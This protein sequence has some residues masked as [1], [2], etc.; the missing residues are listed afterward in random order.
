MKKL[1]CVL[2]ALIIVAAALPFGAS[3]AQLNAVL[4]P[5]AST[6]REND[7]VVVNLNFSN[8]KSVDGIACLDASI[9]YNPNVLEFVSLKA[10]SSILGLASSVP[11]PGKLLINYADAGGGFTAFNKNGTFVAI[12]F[13]VKK[14]APLGETTVTGTLSNILDPNMVDHTASLSSAKINILQPLSDNAFLSELK[15]NPGNLSPAFN[16]N[17]INYAVSVPY[18]VDKIEVEAKAEDSKAK[19]SISNPTLKAGSTTKITITVT[20]ENPSVKKVYTIN[21]TRGAN[22]NPTSS[23][24]SSSEPSS[25]VESSQDSG[26]GFE[27]ESSSEDE[28]L[29]PTPGGGF[30]GAKAV[31]IWILG[32]ILALASGFV[33]GIFWERKMGHDDVP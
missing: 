31:I 12:T 23:A 29:E 9:E 8:A 10:D 15:I 26:G 1:T 11:Q 13:K 5:G 18:S 6:A 16:K 19:V 28:S 33:G 20:A 7:T 22:P 21:V 30:G 32:I 25:E 2:F 3:A 4:A 14:G 27:E 17:V 24:V